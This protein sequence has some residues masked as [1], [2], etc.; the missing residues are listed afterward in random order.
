MIMTCVY[1][2]CCVCLARKE[3]G[4]GW[5][6]GPFDI[7]LILF[8][9]FFHTCHDLQAPICWTLFTT[10]NGPRLDRVSQYQQNAAPVLFLMCQFSL[11]WLMLRERTAALVDFM[12]GG[13]GSF[14]IELCLLI[15]K[16]VSFKSRIRVDTTKFYIFILFWITFISVHSHR[17]TRKRKFLQS[18][19]CKA[20]EWSVRNL[21]CCGLLVW[22][23][24][25]TTI[26]KW[27][28]DSTLTVGLL[29]GCL[30][31]NFVQTSCGSWHLKI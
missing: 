31:T 16:P 19:S 7:T 30:S 27:F 6:G 1:P 9:I 5:G 23:R 10:F 29:L 26:L 28:Y 12:G 15:G 20:L 24:L 2:I 14:N 17:D 3:W 22:G 18:F 21:L 8:N 25:C 11:I 4:G 13:G